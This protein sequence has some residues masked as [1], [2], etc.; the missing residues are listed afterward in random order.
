MSRLLLASTSLIVRCCLLPSQ[1]LPQIELERE[2]KEAVSR[3]K[4]LV[5]RSLEA[6]QKLAEAM[7]KV[8]L[9]WL[10]ASATTQPLVG[11][12]VQARDAQAYAQG[13]AALALSTAV[14]S[15]SAAC[16]CRLSV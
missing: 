13:G 10:F 6:E 11:A 7:R 16:R 8:G 5:E 1:T 4:M 9:R 12:G 3:E 2:A 14:T 15:R